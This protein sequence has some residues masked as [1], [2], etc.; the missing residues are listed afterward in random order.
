MASGSDYESEPETPILKK[1]PARHDAEWDESSDES[2]EL[3]SFTMLIIT[4]IH[5]ENFC[6]SKN[7]LSVE[8]IKSS[9]ALLDCLL[10]SK[11][12]FSRCC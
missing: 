4:L 6:Q 7:Y 1:A 2:L 11:W 8:F 12:I 10:Y 9:L 3:V 5:L